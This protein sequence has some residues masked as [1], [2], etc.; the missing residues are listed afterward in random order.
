MFIAV[1]VAVFRYLLCKTKNFRHKVDRWNVII[2]SFICGFAILFEPATRRSEL[3]MYL[4][5][6]ALESMYNYYVQKGMARHYRYAE[7]LIFAFC[8]SLI[9]YC[10]ET[11]P[12]N[13]KPAYHSLLKRFFGEN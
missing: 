3:T 2:A 8:M 10:Y 13:I 6:R 1:Y 7:V 4:V 12:E 5:P 11:T 9:M